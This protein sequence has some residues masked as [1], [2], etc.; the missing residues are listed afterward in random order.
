MNYNNYNRVL[1]VVVSQQLVFYICTKIMNEKENIIYH[2]K[3]AM[4]ENALMGHFSMM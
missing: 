4:A 3:Y 2:L 1:L